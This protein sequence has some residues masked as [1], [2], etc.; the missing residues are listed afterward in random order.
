MIVLL[1]VLRALKLQAF[2]IWQHAS[3]AHFLFVVVG[4]YQFALDS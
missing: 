4:T 1:Q 3:V 2:L